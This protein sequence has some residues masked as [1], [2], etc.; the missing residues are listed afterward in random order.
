MAFGMF[1]LGLYI[2]QPEVPQWRIKQRSYWGTSSARCVTTSGVPTEYAPFSIPNKKTNPSL[3]YPVKF[4]QSDQIEYVLAYG[5]PFDFGITA[6][7]MI[8]INRPATT[9]KPPRISIFG[10]ARFI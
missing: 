10:R 3:L 2:H 1:L 8:V 5:T 4:C 6:Q 7:T 9:V